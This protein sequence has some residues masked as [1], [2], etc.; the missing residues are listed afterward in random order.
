[1]QCAAA[2]LLTGSTRVPARVE[3]ASGM[4][5]G[6]PRKASGLVTALLS[7]IMLAGCS[8]EPAPRSTG[9]TVQHPSQAPEPTPSTTTAPVWRV[10][11][12]PLPRRPDG[13]GQVL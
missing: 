5:D 6:V 1:M 12:T 7:V 13:F 2:A 4:L 8:A 9:A 11:A 3:S 10:G